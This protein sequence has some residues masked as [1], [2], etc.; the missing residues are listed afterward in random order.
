[1]NDAFCFRGV[2]LDLARQIETVEFIKQFTDM[3]A[4]NGYNVLF[5]YLEGRVRTE[6]FPY[7]ADNECYTL[8]QMREVVEYA[9]TRNIEVI[10]GISLLG[11][12]E[13]FLKYQELTEMAELR[14]GQDGR[15]WNNNKLDFCPSQEA[16]YSFFEKYLK[17]VCDIFPS[18]YFHIGLDEVWDIGYCEK[19]K[20]IASDFSGEQQLFLN[21][22]LRCRKILIGLGKRVMMWDDMFEYYWDILEE[23]PRD[24][25]MVNWQYAAD[26]KHYK[27]HFANLKVKHVLAEYE[28][29]GFKY[30]IAPSDYSSANVRTFTEYAKNFKP[31]GGLVTSWEKKTCFMYKSFPTIAYA[32]QLWK[33][34]S[35]KCETEIFAD[36]M[37]NL[38]GLR[39]EKSLTV[40]RYHT[41]R[42]LNLKTPVT[43]NFLFNSNFNGYDYAD[44]AALRLLKLN[45]EDMM[46]K[47]TIESGKLIIT[48]MILGCRYNILKSRLQKTTFALFEPMMDNKK[49]KL[50]LDMIYTNVKALGEERVKFWHQ[51]RK[52]IEPC[53]V[54][55]LFADCLELIESLP[56][57][58]ANN[59][60]MRVRFCLPDGHSSENCIFSLKYDGKWNKVSTGGCK[61]ANPEIA[62]FSKIFLIPRSIE[63]ES[64]KIEVMGY[65]GQGI[66]FVEIF[67][68]SGHYVPSKVVSVSGKVIDPEFVLD[69]DCKWC[70]MGEKDTL[71]AFKNRHLAEEIH[72][73]EYSL[74]K[75]N[76]KL[77]HE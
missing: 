57:L 63:P 62:L 20:P 58:V 31:L 33:G 32:G 76:K 6:S 67:I 72:S 19:C 73:A 46:P 14:D 51:Y 43:L 55:K 3:I 75:K 47:V 34:E 16:T 26:V 41:E 42:K 44:Y 40:L 35:K 50:E 54:E 37:E 45:L 15:F 9:A 60:L 64:F 39:D 25:I 59:G 56:K 36:A 27:G 21:N 38:F 1:M 65:G 22:L 8:A 13:L 68:D 29:L 49:A 77:N 28:R 12:A 30:I 70:F 18:E 7:P 74:V 69:N 4:D 2:Q 5:L 61:A 24:V 52:G 17:E 48:D 23:V 53:N 11:H 71:K 66:A 10:P